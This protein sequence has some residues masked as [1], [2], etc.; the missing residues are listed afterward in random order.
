MQVSGFVNSY[1]I[2]NFE[3]ADRALSQGLTTLYT[4]CVMLAWHI[5]AV[6]I[7]FI[8]DYASIRVCLFAHVCCLYFTTI[9]LV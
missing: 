5:N 4:R 1:K 9:G 8:A 7:V 6:L 3:T 2:F